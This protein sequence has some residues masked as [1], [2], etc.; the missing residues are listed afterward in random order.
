MVLPLNLAMTKSE[1]EAADTLP[2]H[3]AWMSC[4]FA[5][6]SEGISGIPEALPEGSM[7]ILTDRE[8]CTGHSRDLVVSQLHDAVTR[9]GCESVLLDFQRAPEPESKAMVH[10]IT[11]ALPCPTGVTEGFAEQLSC[12]V[13][14]APCPPD[15]PLQEHL[16]PWKTREIWLEAA[17]CQERVTVTKSGTTFSRIF[18]VLSLSGGFFSK[19]LLC[20]Y[21]TAV[22]TERIT[23][24]LFDTPETLTQK[25]EAARLLGVSRAV[26]LYQELGCLL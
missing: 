21:H 26:G 14:L 8:S 3:P 10:A 12:P 4:H 1:I 25:L 24:T 17:L 9:L 20:R 18:P 22:S 13:F 5:V 7:L 6:G 15:V 2:A 11:E 16:Q 23:F 19:K